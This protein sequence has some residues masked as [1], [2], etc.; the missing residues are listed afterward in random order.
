MTTEAAEAGVRSDDEG[1]VYHGHVILEWPQPV[2]TLTFPRA[3]VAWK[4]AVYDAT[5]GASITTASEITV[6][7]SAD[8]W[9]TADLTMLADPDGMPVLSGSTVYPDDE[10]R[11]RTGTFSFLVAEMRVRS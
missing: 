6:R 11:A 5:D 4:V 8:G 7:A 1:P 2:T 10:G 3:M 9:V